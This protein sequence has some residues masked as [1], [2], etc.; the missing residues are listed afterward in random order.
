MSTTTVHP[1]RFL[2]HFTTATALVFTTIACGVTDESG[3]PDPRAGEAHF[4]HAEAISRFEG[5]T[6]VTELYAADSGDMVATAEWDLDARAGVLTTAEASIPIEAGFD[7]LAE[8]ATAEPLTLQAANALAYSSWEQQLADLEV[9]HG[10]E[11]YIDN[12]PCETCVNC[13][14]CGCGVIEDTY[15]CWCFVV[16]GGCFDNGQCLAA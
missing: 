11:C 1:K 14:D 12:Y 16:G 5:G 3:P 7:D 6:I 9:A 2:T 10:V 13:S 4:E 8:A 15:H